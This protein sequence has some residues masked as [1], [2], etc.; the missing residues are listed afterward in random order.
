MVNIIIKSFQLTNSVRNSLLLW[1]QF[2]RYFIFEKF[3]S[4]VYCIFFKLFSNF[5]RRI[6]YGTFFFRKSWRKFQFLIWSISLSTSFA[7][8]FASRYFFFNNM[9]FISEMISLTNVYESRSFYF[10]RHFEQK[11]YIFKQIAICI[12]YFSNFSKINVQRIL[13]FI[14]LYL[15]FHYNFSLLLL[16][17]YHHHHRPIANKW[18]F[19]TKFLLLLL[20][21][22]KLPLIVIAV[23]PNFSDL[24]YPNRNS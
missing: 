10:Q 20:R 2:L 9:R 1:F 15:L 8:N 16:W 13:T 21:V 4:V 12:I 17:W 7:C 14:L 18:N 24:E 22:H 19:I 6:C 3:C 23:L 11:I 5:D